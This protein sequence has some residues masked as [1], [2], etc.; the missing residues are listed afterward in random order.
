MHCHTESLPY[1]NASNILNEPPHAITN[2]MT[3]APSEDADQTAPSLIRV[4]AVRLNK[5]WILSYLLSASEDSSQPGRMHRLIWVFAEHT[6]HFVD[7]VMHRLNISF[8][9]KK[10]KRKKDSFTWTLYLLSRLIMTIFAQYYMYQWLQC[11]I[12]HAIDSRHISPPAQEEAEDVTLNHSN[13]KQ[14]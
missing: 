2:K 12:T 13:I 5:G 3:C 4:F 11:E 6:C 14:R 9:Q 10:K 8:D 1:L 7:F